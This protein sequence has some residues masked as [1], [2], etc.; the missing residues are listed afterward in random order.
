MAQRYRLGFSSL[1]FFKLTRR[2][3]CFSMITLDCTQHVLLSTFLLTTTSHTF[4]GHDDLRTCI[5]LRISGIYKIS[6]CACVNFPA[7]SFTITAGTIREMAN[8]TPGPNSAFYSIFAETN[9]NSFAG[10]RWP[11]KIM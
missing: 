2:H 3:R 4:P 10:Q 1:I 7:H 8:N 5:P 9:C 6:V 11:H